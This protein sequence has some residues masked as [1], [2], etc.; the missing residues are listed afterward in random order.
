MR[1][2]RGAHGVLVLFATASVLAGCR[3][4][5]TPPSRRA[6]A[7]AQLGAVALCTNGMSIAD[8]A[9]RVM[10]SVVNIVSEHTTETPDVRR[11]H[12]FRLGSGVIVAQDGLIVTNAHVVADAERIAVVLHDGRHLQAAL[13]GSD[14]HSDIAVLRVAASALPA[15]SFADPRG[16]RVGDLVLA[17]GDPFGIGETVTM[18]IVS[19]KGRTNLGIVDVEDFIQTDAAINPGSSGGALVDMSGRLIGVNTAIASQNGGNQGVGFAIASDLV[20]RVGD[21]LA[22]TGRVT[23]GWL[24][25]SL[26]DLP[27]ELAARLALPTGGVIVTHVTAGGPAARAGLVS[28]DVIIAIDGAD[29]NNVA[30]LHNAI[31]LAG[32]TKIHVELRR[33]RETLSREVELAS[34]P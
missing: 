3:G 29:T 2:S 34:E 7:R 13:I 22:R 18:G 9:E 32:P 19:A 10:P 11:T 27:R 25:A 23:G 31:V 5:W 16:V 14:L 8:V 1:T 26:T 24:G 30:H 33:G 4:R 21:R 17:I 6:P 28:G 12:A 20:R 15:L